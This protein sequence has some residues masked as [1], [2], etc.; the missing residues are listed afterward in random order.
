MDDNQRNAMNSPWLVPVANA[1]DP[2]PLD[3]RSLTLLRNAA[4]D[5]ETVM[6]L[7]IPNGTAD[8]TQALQLIITRSIR[9]GE[10]NTDECLKQ[11]GSEI[12]G[13]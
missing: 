4:V 1:T 9:I 2:N 13:F 7:L 8:N 12:L 5:Y 6:Y 11:F 10:L 3:I